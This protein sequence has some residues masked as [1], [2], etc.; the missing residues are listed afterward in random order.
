MRMRSRRRRSV[1]LGFADGARNKVPG[2][3]MAVHVGQNG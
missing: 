1:G 3:T 2:L